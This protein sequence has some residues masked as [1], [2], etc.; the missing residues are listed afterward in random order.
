MGGRGVVRR[1]QFG[2]LAAR[3]AD[4]R[5]GLPARDKCFPFGA[6]GSKRPEGVAIFRFVKEQQRSGSPASQRMSRMAEAIA[7]LW[8][9]R[10]LSLL[11][12]SLAFGPRALAGE[13]R[14]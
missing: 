11:V 4:C 7:A 9:V 8:L 5:Y 13:E 2:I 3:Q 14:G 12:L 1:V 6:L 10:V